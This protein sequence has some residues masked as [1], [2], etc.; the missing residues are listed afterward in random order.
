MKIG[1]VDTEE[2]IVLVAEIGNNHEGSFHLAQEL[3]GQASEAGADAVKLQTLIPEYFVSHRDRE[4]LDTMR[5]FALSLAD[6]EKLITDAAG[7][8]I[9]VFSTPLDLVS[10]ASL[11]PLVDTIKVAS[12][13]ITFTPL[14]EAVASSGLD[15]IISTGAST[16]VEVGIAVGVLESIWAQDEVAPSLGILHCVSNYPALPSSVNLRAIATLAATF[17]SATIGYSDHTIGVEAAVLAAAAGA[18]I[19]E[20]HFTLDKE[21]S[22]FRD[23]SLSADAQDLR[24]L[25]DCLDRVELLLGKE[26]KSPNE[27]EISLIPT[28]RRSL[29]VTKDLPVGST[30][31]RT[32]LQCLRPEG[33]LPPSALSA[34][35]GRRLVVEKR[36][37]EPLFESDLV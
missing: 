33:G 9:Y 17:P 22:D 25:R 27:S 32:D 19:I 20:K 2:R 36:A 35:I 6:T 10:L 1:S 26:G 15:T 29:A 37:G 7:R 3:I 34:T 21:F 12:G 24:H 31:G 28:I 4:R 30:L 8:G 18:R 23:H 13:D 11:V 5:R 14:I 16:L